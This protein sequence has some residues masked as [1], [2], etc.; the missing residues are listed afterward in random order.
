VIEI[1]KDCIPE[2]VA[3]NLL[4][5]T[6]LQTSFGIINLCLEDGAPAILSVD[7]I[8]KDYIEFQVPSS[9]AGPNSY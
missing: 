1:R 3:N 5:H 2:V 6:Q 7:K 9:P 4:K 8:I